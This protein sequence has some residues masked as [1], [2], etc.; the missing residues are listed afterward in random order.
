MSYLDSLNEEKLESF[1]KE[2][3]VKVKDNRIKIASIAGGIVTFLIVVV[4]IVFSFLNN[5]IVPDMSDWT[6]TEVQV[7]T[8]ENNIKVIPAEEYNFA[9]SD[10]VIF[11]S[12]TAG[13]KLD[14]G[15]SIQITFSKG[16]NPNEII[17]LPSLANMFEDEVKI[18]V[19]DNKLTGIS[20]KYEYSAAFEKGEVIKYDIIDGSESE[21]KRKNR[22][23]ITVS[24]GEEQV[25]DLIEV[26]NLIEQLESQAAKWASDNGI[27]LNI[28]YQND[29]YVAK[30]KIIS[31]SVSQGYEIRRNDTL[32]IYV[33]LGKEITVPDFTFYTK[34]EAKS[35]ASDQ[36]ITLKLE[37]KYSSSIPKGLRVSQSVEHN[38]VISESDELTVVYSLGKIDIYSYTGRSILDFKDFIESEN[39]KGA[40]LTYLITYEASTSHANGTVI[41]HDFEHTEINPGTEISVVVSIGHTIIVPDFSDYTVE[42]AKAWAAE[43]GVTVNI[44]YEY[45]RSITEGYAKRQS[46]QK[47]TEI[48]RGDEIVIYFSLGLVN[49]DDFEGM[50]ITEMRNAVDAMNREGANINLQ[51]EFVFSS[52]DNGT[53]ISHEYTF[54][55]VIPGTAISV[56][57]SKGEAFIVPD[58]V[59]DT[60]IDTFSEALDYCNTNDLNCTWKFDEGGVQNQV[61]SQSVQPKT[62]IGK[63]EEIEIHIYLG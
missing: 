26:P 59:N 12:V 54:E 32:T 61:A 13:E 35:W 57:V 41:S 43:Y 6:M 33:S 51:E 50:T 40:K 9:D 29:A 30:G 22:I 52:K 14:K 55:E 46:I 20:F 49:I 7:W 19:K 5:V 47:K 16:P 23:Q 25:S 48:Q 53:I 17:E 2:E 60:A 42:Q 18:W 3:F 4:I 36:G 21:F 44:K 8:S 34:E 10:H 37:E 39:V 45:A 62:A 28:E 24:K 11:Q 38:E 15:D 56:I 27:T 1:Q 31:Q 63:R 58:F